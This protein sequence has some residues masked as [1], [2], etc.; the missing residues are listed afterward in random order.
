VGRRELEEIIL[1]ARE[2]EEFRLRLI[3]DPR[4]IFEE[5][6]L[7]ELEIVALQSGDTRLLMRLGVRADLAASPPEV[8]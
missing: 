7:S 4:S 1:R 3:K 5:Y 6:H 8:T 2:D